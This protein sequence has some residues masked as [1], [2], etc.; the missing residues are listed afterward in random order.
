M[1]EFHVK[2]PLY[3]FF[4]NMKKMSE[5]CKSVKLWRFITKYF[6]SLC[7]TIH[8]IQSM[9]V[10]K[11]ASHFSN[12]ENDQKILWYYQIIFMPFICLQ[13]FKVKLFSENSLWSSILNPLQMEVTPKKPHSCIFSVYII[14]KKQEF[15]QT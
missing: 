10:H 6:V 11:N 7:A 5:F 14:L 2:E 1:K 9:L 3:I 8:T 13:T 15:F 12:Q 4:Y